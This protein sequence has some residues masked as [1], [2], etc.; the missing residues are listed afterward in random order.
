MT[1]TRHPKIFIGKIAAYPERKVRLMVEQLSL[2]AKR[3][4]ERELRRLLNGCLPEANIADGSA[5]TDQFDK[6]CINDESI[7]SSAP[8][9]VH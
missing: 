5:S 8:S 6:T 4:E 2:L 7:E 3:G 1:K 9:I